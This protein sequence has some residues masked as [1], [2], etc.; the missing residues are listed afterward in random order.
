M[1]HC[2]WMPCGSTILKSGSGI[3]GSL[4]DQDR[5]EYE[6][7]D[8]SGR[9]PETCTMGEDRRHRTLTSDCGH[10]IEGAGGVLV[11]VFTS[12]IGEHYRLIEIALSP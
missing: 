4:K 2:S 1:I 7:T 10:I 9:G 11:G 12:R 8:S 6:A 5:D 3:A